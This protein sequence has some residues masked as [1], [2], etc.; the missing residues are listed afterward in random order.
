MKKNDV[1]LV[2][3]CAGFIGYF[4]CKKLLEQNQKV[5][6]IDS[7]NNYYDTSFKKKRKKFLKKE[8]LIFFKNNLLNTSNIEK[9]IKYKVNVIIT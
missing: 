5:I 8:K 7:L 3:G 2:T 1:Y 9:I 6:G 4:L